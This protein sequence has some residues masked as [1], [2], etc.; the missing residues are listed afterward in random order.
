MLNARLISFY[1]ILHLSSSHLAALDNGSPIVHEIPMQNETV[2]PDQYK[3]LPLVAKCCSLN[4]VLVKG[5]TG[6]ICLESNS[7]TA[8]SPLFSDFNKTGVLTPG[9]EKHIFVAIIGD[10]CN[11]KRYMLSPEDSSDD[12][13]YLL[14][15]GSIFAPHHAPLMLT[16]GVD[17]CMEIIPDLGLRAL[18]CFPK[19]V[20]VAV[21]DSR[22]TLYACGLLISVP[23]LILTIAA[24]CITP[25]L[26]DVHGKALCYY[27]ACLAVAFTTLAIVQLASDKLSDQFCICIAFIIQFSFVTCFFWLNVMCVETWLSVRNHVL[28]HDERSSRTYRRID[29][30][31]LFCYYSIWAW[32]PSALLVIISMIMDLSPTIPMTYVKPNFGSERCW[33]KSDE[34]AMPYFYVPVGLLLLCNMILFTM[35]AIKITKYQQELALRRL[36]RYQESDREDQRIFRRLKRT[37]L[38]CLVLFFLMGLNW[39]M[40]LISWWA[41]GDPLDWSAFDLVNALQGVLV[42]GLFVLRK[43][44]RDFIWQQI[45]QFRGIHVAEPGLGS[46]D[47]SL[48]PLNG[49][50]TDSTR[51]IIIA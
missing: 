19:D 28:S 14:L 12:E 17:Y 4:E 33:F 5:A 10:P 36:A 39:S 18:V 35:T 30:G 24:Y 41:G 2:V 26:R 20:G 6:T 51:Q 42:F 37:F 38:V 29:P 45:Q 15:N 16:P 46:M 22:I 48:L 50:V 49:D 47:V 44:P 34:E 3:N 31:K 8:F 11:N 40:E 9:D 43:P 25:K 21:A 23:F 27:C 13:Y 7:T 1:L 32:G